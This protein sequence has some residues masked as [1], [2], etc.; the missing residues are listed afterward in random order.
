[1]APSNGFESSTVF[2]IVTLA[3]GCG[4]LDAEEDCRVPFGLG[5][6]AVSVA[7]LTIRPDCACTFT[8]IFS[9]TVRPSRRV[10]IF[11]LIVWTPSR[12]A[13]LT[14]PAADLAET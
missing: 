8:T 5:V 7:V 1:M 4:E 9:T 10:P 2:L 3:A 12:V 14:D 11:Q 13:S 6:V